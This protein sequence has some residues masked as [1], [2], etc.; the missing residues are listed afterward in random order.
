MYFSANSTSSR[1]AAWDEEFTYSRLHV[2]LLM[3]KDFK[4]TSHWAS[5]QGFQ[6]GQRDSLGRRRIWVFGQEGQWSQ[7]VGIRDTPSPQFR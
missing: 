4:E 2:T 1:V 5:R 6:V 7:N 3:N